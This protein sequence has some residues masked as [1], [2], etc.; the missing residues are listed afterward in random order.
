[1]QVS[2]SA[3]PNPAYIDQNVS[4][5]SLVTGGTGLYTYKWVGACSG[6]K[7]NCT[8]AFAKTGNYPS[9]ITVT[10]GTEKK[11]AF[12]QVNV[13]PICVDSDGGKHTYIRGTIKIKGVTKVQD[14]CHTGKSV[15]EYFC[16]E[17]GYS[18]QVY[19]CP[20]GCSAG[21]CKK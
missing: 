15:K 1:L 6:T 17:N 18:S 8:K 5:T 3:A 14:T 19:N 11:Y 13:I 16:S 20:K 2:C 7:Q 4:Y 10:S 21:A 9:Q 12:C